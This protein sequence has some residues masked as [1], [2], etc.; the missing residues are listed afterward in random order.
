[1]NAPVP[2]LKNCRQSVEFL[3]FEFWQ[4][5]LQGWSADAIVGFRILQIEMTNIS[6]LKA[7]K[8]DRSR[9]KIGKNMDGIKQ[10]EVQKQSDK[11]VWA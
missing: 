6:Q 5:N 7:E 1:M 4:I 10:I 2:K 3:K 9:F 8:T 11:I